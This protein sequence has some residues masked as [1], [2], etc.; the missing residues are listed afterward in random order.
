MEIALWI[1][2]VCEVAR[3]VQN[4]IQLR[5]IHHSNG[6]YDNACNEFVKSMKD[7]DKVFV[8]KLLEE[9]EKECGDESSCS[10]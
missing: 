5:A 1:I 2:A 7:T 10:L 4:A 3:A 6:A 8:R 9:I